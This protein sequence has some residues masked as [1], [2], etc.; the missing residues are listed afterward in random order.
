MKNKGR[1]LT[2][3]STRN[4][5]IEWYTPP[6][7]F[8]AIGL[9]FDLDPC[10]PGV[11]KSFVPADNHYTLPTDG[12]AS[13][14]LGTVWVN[15]PYGRATGKWLAKLAAHGDGIALVFARTDNKWAQSTLSQAD[16]VCF[17]AGRLRFYKGDLTTE[18]GPPGCGS[19]LIAFGP[20]CAVA[21]RASGLGFCMT[22][23][24]F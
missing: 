5:S 12:L 24:R 17:I 2:H 9:Q 4:E 22:S 8:E 3:E 14:W 1:G 21:V 19:M 23:D 7:I 15:P 10:S 13:P 11:G 20:K 18:G 6:R 16:V